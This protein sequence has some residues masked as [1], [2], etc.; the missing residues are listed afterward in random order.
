MTGATGNDVLDRIRA[1]LS[2]D[3]VPATR[4]PHPGSFTGYPDSAPPGDETLVARFGQQLEALSGRMHRA[5]DAAE[6]A[7]IVVEVASRVEARHIVSWDEGRLG[8]PG[9]H[10]RLRASG[11]EVT[12]LELPDDPAARQALLLETGKIPVGLTGA[13]AAL[14][15]TGTIVLAS[16]PGCARLVSLLPPVHVAIVSQR[17]LYPSLP[18][19]LAAHPGLVAESSNVVL[20]T[21][22]SRTA[23]IEMTLTHGVHGPREIHVIVMP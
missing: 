21:G 22:P 10:A 20:V 16:G 12:G 3:G 13:Q 15:D 5:S 1:A 9:L 23:D 19:C 7:R 4:E 14:A 17:T 11:I 2:K 18:S 6:A 8:C